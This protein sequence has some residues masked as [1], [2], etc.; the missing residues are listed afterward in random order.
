MRSI[1]RRVFVKDGAFSVLGVSMVPGFL[2]RAAFAARPDDATRKT[3]VA[4]FQRG[5]VDGLNVVVPFGDPHYFE[6]RPSIAVPAPSKERASAL[7]LDGYF[8]LHPAL[9]PLHQLY[10]RGEL[11]VIQAVGSPHETRSHFE[12]QDYMESAVPGDKKVTDGWLNRYLHQ[13]QHPEAGSFRAVAMG[14]VLPKTLSGPAPALALGDMAPTGA[15]S[16]IAP[17]YESL[18]DGESNALV[19]ASAL[20]MFEALRMLKEHD[21]RQYRT[22]ANVRYPAGPFAAGLRS[23]AQLIKA[24]VGVEIAFVD[25]GGWDTHNDQGSLEDGELPPRLRQFGLALSAF[26]QDLGDRME[27]VVVLTMSEFGRTARENGNAGTDHGKANSM[28]V[29]GGGVKG[30]RI[31]GD[32]PGLAPE[33]LNEARDLAMTTDFRNVFAEILVGHLGCKD[34]DAIFQDFRPDRRSFKGLL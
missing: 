13:N 8:G 2:H 14:P 4:I 24:D 5:G 19:S 32:W 20:E 26:Y 30:G 18:Y 1:S 17:V 21:P 15:V 3:F 33:Q 25:V 6:Y 31:Y 34:P 12:A 29:M 16:E 23:L 11:A 7:D 9:S 28:F 10:A 27:D 22:A